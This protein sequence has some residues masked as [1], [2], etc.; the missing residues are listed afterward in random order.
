MAVASAARGCVRNVGEATV[1]VDRQPDGPLGDAER[2]PIPCLADFDRLIAAELRAGEELR[3]G[4]KDV[5]FPGE[6]EPGLHQK[7]PLV[8]GHQAPTLAPHLHAAE[9]E[10]HG[11]GVRG[12][13]RLREGIQQGSRVLERI[14][15]QGRELIRV[16]RLGRVVGD[17][18]RDDAV[19][20]L[21]RDTAVA[22]G[23]N[24]DRIVLLRLAVEEELEREPQAVSAGRRRRRGIRRPRRRIWHGRRGRPATC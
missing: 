12:I 3:F 10:P 16:E 17:D 22:S 24:L 1:L 23:L 20:P 2:H 8:R 18:L 13:R 5:I 11:T 9:G 19:L 7:L 15:R 6:H 21:G 4:H 14:S